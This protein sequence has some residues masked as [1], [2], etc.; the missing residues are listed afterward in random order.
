MSLR[1]DHLETLFLIQAIALIEIALA[2]VIVRLLDLH[3]P[4]PKNASELAERLRGNYPGIDPKR[5]SANKWAWRAVVIT[6]GIT[7]ILVFAA[8]RRG[9]L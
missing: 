8:K 7:M 4:F 5:V 9:Y 6:I 3:L 1:P 2:L